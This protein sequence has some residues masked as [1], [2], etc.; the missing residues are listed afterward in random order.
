[1]PQP[2]QYADNAQRQAAYRARHADRKPP[3][4]DRLAAQARA[5]HFVMAEAIAKDRCPLPH[6]ILGVRADE[7]M[8]N[9]I[10]YLDPDPDPVRYHGMEGMPKATS[11]EAIARRDLNADD[12]HERGG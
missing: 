5:L 3:R 2:K 9:L 7:T 12:S 8:R 10:Y 4:E 1:V 11:D 6:R